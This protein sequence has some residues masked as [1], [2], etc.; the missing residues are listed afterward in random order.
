MGTEI[1]RALAVFKQCIGPSPKSK[2]I[3][4]SILFKDFFSFSFFLSF[5][6][7]HYSH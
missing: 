6:L 7:I 2:L 5:W 4:L 3:D 1:A